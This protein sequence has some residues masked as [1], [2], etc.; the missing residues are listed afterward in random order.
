MKEEDLKYIDS[1][2]NGN[3]TEQENQTFKAKLKEDL[4]FSDSYQFVLA[5][6]A[7][8]QKIEAERIKKLLKSELDDENEEISGNETKVINFNSKRDKTEGNQSNTKVFNLWPVLR[9][10]SIAASLVLIILVWQPFKSSNDAIFSSYTSGSYNTPALEAPSLDIYK[11]DENL[12]GTEFAF[13]GYTQ[14]EAEE[15]LASIDLINKREFSQAEQKLS[16]IL[17]PQEANPD[18]VLYLAI[19]QLNSNKELVAVS[20][21]EKLIK[22][23]NYQ[24][25]ADVKFHLAMAYIKIGK[26]RKARTLLKDISQ[27]DNKFSNEARNILKE[28]RWF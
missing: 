13:K 2:L 25:E 16:S 20:N 18:L 8:S 7:A 28:I 4:E 21:F 14:L 24:N 6:Q 10:T 11:T 9:Y 26:V 23:P 19:A 1:Y 3:L 5:V 27:D 15:I 22:I 17:K 12:R